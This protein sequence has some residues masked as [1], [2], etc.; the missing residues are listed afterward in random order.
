MQQLQGDSKGE[1]IESRLVSS[2]P[3][4]SS[5]L[6][7]P[8]GKLPQTYHRQ[9]RQRPPVRE[10]LGFIPSLRPEGSTASLSF[11]TFLRLPRKRPRPFLPLHDL[12]LILPYTSRPDATVCA[13][14]SHSTGRLPGDLPLGSS[15]R[16]VNLL[17]HVHEVHMSSIRLPAWC[18]E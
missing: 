13:S 4:R 3:R 9:T 11:Q 2:I 17:T 18:G 15:G 7:Q 8:R 5:F 12:Y 16:S 10:V 14:E 1:R 6:S